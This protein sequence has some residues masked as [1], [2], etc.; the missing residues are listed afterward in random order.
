MGIFKRT[1]KG[2][3]GN[4]TD[5]WY[6]DYAVDGK[7]KWEAVGKVGEVSKEDAK[8][9]LSLRK[10]EILQGKFNAPKPKVIPTF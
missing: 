7:R 9:L 8:K 4:K 3:D 1:I 5:H 6:I 10:T 2:K